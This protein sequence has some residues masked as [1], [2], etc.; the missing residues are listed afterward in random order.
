MSEGALIP[1][2]THNAKGSTGMG[3]L[4]YGVNEAA[5]HAECDAKDIVHAIR[6]GE[7]LARVEG[8]RILIGSAALSAWV[9]VNYPAA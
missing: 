2:S 9:I 3:S 1:N 5:V 6:A 7:I 4:V 8:T